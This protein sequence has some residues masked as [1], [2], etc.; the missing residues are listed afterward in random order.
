MTQAMK[1]DGKPYKHQRVCR[2][3][4]NTFE[5]DSERSICLACFAENITLNIRKL[6][7]AIFDPETFAKEAI[8]L[9]KMTQDVHATGNPLPSEL[10]KPTEEARSKITI[11]L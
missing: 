2:S 4:G 5:T 11:E 6:V 3:C 7:G 9:K 10:T 8:G 1:L